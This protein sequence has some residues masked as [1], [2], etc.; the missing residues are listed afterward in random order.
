MRMVVLSGHFDVVRKEIRGQKKEWIQLL[1]PSDLR[2]CGG[3]LTL[4]Q[5][6]SSD[7]SNNSLPQISTIG[8]G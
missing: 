4:G 1:D 5:V 2:T 8:N 3:T 7:Y 6:A